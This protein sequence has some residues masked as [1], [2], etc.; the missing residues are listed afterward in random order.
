MAHAQLCSSTMV[1]DEC[2]SCVASAPP[3]EAATFGQLGAH[4]PACAALPA[5]QQA[6]R[7]Q[8]RRARGT[9]VRVRADRTILQIIANNFSISEWLRT[10]SLVRCG[11]QAESLVPGTAAQAITAGLARKVTTLFCSADQPGAA[12]HPA[13]GCGDTRRQLQSP[14]GANHVF[15]ADLQA[16]I[17]HI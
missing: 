8:Q 16:A 5:V 6:V 11:L 4:L 10:L 9:D 1:P 3:E 7:Y 13:G 12:W 2:G 14:T 17:S 15:D